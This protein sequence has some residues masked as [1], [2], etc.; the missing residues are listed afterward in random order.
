MFD[1]FDRS[2]TYL[3][4]SVTHA[5][6]LRCVYCAPPDGAPQ[7][8]RA[9]LLTPEQMTEVARAA[10][11][12]GVTKIRL[13]GGEPLMRPDIVELVRMLAG[14]DGLAHIAMTTNA[15]L[16]APLAAPLRDAGL[17]SV[18]ISLDT[19]DPARYRELTRGGNLDSALAGLHAALAVHLRVKVN[20]VILGSTTSAEISGLRDFC[21][22][23]GAR[24]QLIDH[25]D[26][27]QPKKERAAMDRPPP[28]GGCNRIRLMADGM[29]KPCL[30]ANDEI[31]LDFSR[32]EESLREAILSKPR[33]GGVCTNRAMS[34]IGG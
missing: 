7:R 25:F 32:L 1:R 9:D 14:I 18:N 15:T 31:P 34:Q 19:L 28:C 8:S 22:A 4:I 33:R 21:A 16:L 10:V 24:L 20:M 2:I 29:L 6:N 13:T 26:L 12:L 27:S 3:R 23:S 11:R 5:C 30:Q 17:Q